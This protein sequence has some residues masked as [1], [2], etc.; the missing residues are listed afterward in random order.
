MKQKR[1]AREEQEKKAGS[2]LFFD[3]PYSI[4][5]QDNKEREKLRRKGGKELTEI[6][7]K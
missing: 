3:F 4:I 2:A 5:L 1:A 6:K 7:Q